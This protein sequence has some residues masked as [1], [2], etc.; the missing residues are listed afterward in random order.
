MAADRVSGGGGQG[1]GRGHEEVLWTSY[2][3]KQGKI[4]QTS[5]LLAFF[6][7]TI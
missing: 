2:R 5:L 1:V 7:N 4:N 3:S 6:I